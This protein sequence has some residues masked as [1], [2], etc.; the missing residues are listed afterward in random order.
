MKKTL[1]QGPLG[2][3]M[4]DAVARHIDQLM[5]TLPKEC[6]Y[7]KV[8]AVP[9]SFDLIEGERADVSLVS[10]DALDR[11]GDVILPKGVD[12]SW[13]RMNP[14]VLANHNWE[15]PMAVVGK[16]LWIKAQDRGI[17]A[18]TKYADKPADWSGP[19]LPDALLAMAQQGILKGKS[20][21]FLPTSIRNPTAEELD[22]NP[23][24]KN[25]RGV[26]DAAILLEYS[27][28]GIPCNAEALTLAVSKGI[29]DAALLKKL[30]VELPAAP[31]VQPAAKAPKKRPNYAAVLKALKT[32]KLDPRKIAEQAIDRVRGRSQ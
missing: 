3:P 22:R 23:A 24:W 30:G 16:A 32:M 8:A 25:A 13:F 4:L 6:T 31:P 26:I 12:L 15:D 9:Q 27:V 14:V 11:E 1:C 29:A 5:K 17:L 20:I 2:F 7:R 18:K 10:T 28:V 19:W 21:G